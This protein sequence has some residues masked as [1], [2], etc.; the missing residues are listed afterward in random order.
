ML[1]E[2]PALIQL[3]KSR[4][5][6]VEISLQEVKNNNLFL[7]SKGTLCLIHQKLIYYKSKNY[8]FTFATFIYVCVIRKF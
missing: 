4:S 7:C 6:Q 5:Q 1:S 8:I 3:E 2:T